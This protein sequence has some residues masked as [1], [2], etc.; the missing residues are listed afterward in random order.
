[1]KIKYTRALL[2]AALDGSL[3]NVEFKK[4][5]IF[6]VEIP[7]ECPGIP[8]EILSPVNTWQNKSEF[9]K[10]A[11]ALAVRFNENFKKY[12]SQSSPEVCN[13]GPVAREEATA[14]S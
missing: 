12:A 3:N 9:E 2:R 6:A 1:M 8:A 7:A 14:R 4:D 11:N 13:A 10:T 5:P